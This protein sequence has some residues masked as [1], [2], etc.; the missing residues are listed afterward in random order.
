MATNHIQRGKVLSYANATGAAIASGE[1]VVVGT[2]IG[3]ALTDIANGA[4]GE[5]G[6]ED[7]FELP[8]ATGAIAQGAV[9]YWDADGT[10]VGGT[11]G[12]GAATT[13]STDN[14]EAGYAF[15][16]AGESAATVQVKLRG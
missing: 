7:V 16:A 14:V 15:A 4:I 2:R 13:T 8:K 9:V 10:P 6:M 3:M 11:S 12:A 1:V 5:V